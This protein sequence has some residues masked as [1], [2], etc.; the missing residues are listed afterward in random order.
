[1]RNSDEGVAYL[2]LAR[3]VDES[4]QFMTACGLSLDHK[5]MTGA[6]IEVFPS[7]TSMDKREALSGSRQT[8]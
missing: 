6:L 8:C 1:M 4:I 7:S 2:D 5:I 3:R